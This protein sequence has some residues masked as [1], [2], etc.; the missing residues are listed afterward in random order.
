MSS[1]TAFT[2][3]KNFLVANFT[4]APL[5]FEN[6]PAYQTPEPPSPWVLVEI[7]GSMF[8]QVSMGSGMPVT[9]K[10]REEGAVLCHVM[11]PVGTGSLTGRQLATTI[12]N[13]F[14]GLSL[15][16][17]IRFADLSIG[18]GM[19]QIE[20]GNYWPLSC[21]MEWARDTA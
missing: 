17:D 20:D 12:T 10:W 21:R 8:D 14:R 16:P 18:S 3:I 2:A 15:S 19:V 5:V 6:D 7:Y 1:D 11:V 4:S 9:D 13:L